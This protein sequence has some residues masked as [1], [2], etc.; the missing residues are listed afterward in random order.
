MVRKVKIWKV[1]KMGLP[2]VESLSGLQES[3]FSLFRGSQLNSRKK[4]NNW[5]IFIKFFPFPLFPHVGPTCKGEL[6]LTIVTSKPR[7]VS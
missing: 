2:I 4:I 7:I 1:L 3:I 5:S 6:K